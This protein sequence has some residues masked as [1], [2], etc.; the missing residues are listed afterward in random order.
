MARQ[1][2]GAL[3]KIAN[4]QVGVFVAY[5]SELGTALVDHRLFLPDGGPRIAPA[6]PPPGCRVGVGFATTADLGLAMPRQAR[7]HGHLAARWVTADE[8]YGPVPGFR[9]ALDGRGVA[10]RPGGPVATPVFTEAG[11]R[12]SSRPGR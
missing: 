11:R 4:C 5:T 10:L 6:A 7:A 12:Q 3:G 9:D 2:C 8:A 1:Y